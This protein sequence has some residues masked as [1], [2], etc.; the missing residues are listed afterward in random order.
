VNAR[1]LLE[2]RVLEDANRTRGR[3]GKV[4]YKTADERLLVETAERLYIAG[5]INIDLA[6]EGD[7]HR[8]ATLIAIHDTGDARLRELE[9]KRAAEQ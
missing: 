9:E 6:K 2:L 4:T 1:E 3:P 8:S 5:M 7:G